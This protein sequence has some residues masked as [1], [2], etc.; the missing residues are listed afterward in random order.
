MR[1][2]KAAASEMAVAV[3]LAGYC[4]RTQPRVIEETGPV[5][6]ETR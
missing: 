5:P 2:D 3:Y 6:K 4:W 1:V